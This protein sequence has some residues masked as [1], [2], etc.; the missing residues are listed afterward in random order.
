VIDY[1]DWSGFNLL[2]GLVVT[3]KIV[4]GVG[5][6]LGHEIE[7]QEEHKERHSYSE[8]KH[9]D[10]L[11]HFRSRLLVVLP[12]NYEVNQEQTREMRRYLL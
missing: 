8:G 11:V 12:R 3:E 4:N 1:Y 5:L 10:V 7:A 6:V 9:L 2:P